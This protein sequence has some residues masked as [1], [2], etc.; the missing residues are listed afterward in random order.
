MLRRTPYGRN[1][2]NCV[3]LRRRFPHLL[4]NAVDSIPLL[5]CSIPQAQ[6]VIPYTHKRQ[7]QRLPWLI[8]IHVFLPNQPWLHTSPK[9]KPT[10]SDSQQ[11]FSHI[12]STNTLSP[13]RR[14]EEVLIFF[15]TILLAAVLQACPIKGLR[16]QGLGFRI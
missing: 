3:S 4:L 1:I 16:V 10:T 7:N 9:I 5:C 14:A 12:P 13:Q 6:N 2:S 15:S 8:P 11:R